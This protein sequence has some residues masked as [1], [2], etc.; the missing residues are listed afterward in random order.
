MPPITEE[1]S[2]GTIEECIDELDEFI[3]KMDRYAP[4]V[5]AIA[6][7]AHLGE[8][9]RAMVDGHVCTREHVRQFVMELEHEA[10]GVG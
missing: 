7:R 8:L 9:L 3:A 4:P 10:I 1:T 6:L 5:L 2:H